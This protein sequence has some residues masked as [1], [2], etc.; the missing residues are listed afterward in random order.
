MNEICTWSIGVLVVTR[1]TEVLIGDSN[2]DLG[3]LGL[4]WD[5]IRVRAMGGGRQTDG[6]IVQ[7]TSWRL[8][9]YQQ[10]SAGGRNQ[11]NTTR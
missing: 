8:G 2:P 4:I 1:E 9:Q 7:P 11:H 10:N 5:Q 3:P 6:A